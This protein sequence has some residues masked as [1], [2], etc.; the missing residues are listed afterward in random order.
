MKEVI[1]LEQEAND[2]VDEEMRSERWKM[3]MGEVSDEKMR[4]DGR[5]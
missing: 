1:Y 3:L 5:C 2:N 4:S